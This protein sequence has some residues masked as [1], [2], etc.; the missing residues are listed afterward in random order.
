MFPE[1]AQQETA[2]WGALV[3]T[4]VVAAEMLTDLLA[5]CNFV[6]RA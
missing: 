6:G 5:P 2:V 1:K 3:S 4:S